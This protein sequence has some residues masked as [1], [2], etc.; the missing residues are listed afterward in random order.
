MWFYKSL[1]P[2]F[3]AFCGIQF[4]IHHLDYMFQLVETVEVK[5]EITSICIKFIHFFWMSVFTGFYPQTAR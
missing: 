3:I 5:H 2:A 1:A 4:F